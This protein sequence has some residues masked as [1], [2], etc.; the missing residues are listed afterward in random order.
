MLK[1]Q[2]VHY[3]YVQFTVFNYTS[4]KLLKEIISFPKKL[5]I[6]SAKYHENYF[7]N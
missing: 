2:I 7:T 1:H 6:D 3:T 5:F 4:I